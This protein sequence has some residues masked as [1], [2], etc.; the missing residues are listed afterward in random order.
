MVRIVASDADSMRERAAARID[1]LAA[2][3]DGADLGEFARRYYAGVDDA[4]LADRSVDDL[5]NTALNHWRLGRV[6]H[7][8][9]AIVAVRAPA[10]GHTVVDIVNDD[11]PFL[12]DSVT[13]ALDRHDLGIH[14]VLHPILR[15]HR[16]RS[17]GELRGL[18][19]DA[20]HT[21]D[22][23]VL[24]ESWLHIEVDRETSEVALAAVHD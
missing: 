24:L 2:A 18:A 23:D 10:H 5:A 6:R 9:E 11:M 7:A 13:M 3:G 1:A 16:T 17:G 12:V 14:L 21:G 8:G 15:V 4:D 19:H 20:A 22:D